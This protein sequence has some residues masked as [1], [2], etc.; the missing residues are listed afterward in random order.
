MSVKTK[1]AAARLDYAMNWSAWLDGDTLS[2]VAWTVSDAALIVGSGTYDPV[3]TSTLATVWLLAGV[4]G[5]E[6]EV[7]CSITTAAGRINSAA[8]TLVVI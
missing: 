1:V 4:A 2:A 7:T 6:Y 8:F 3:F 5:G